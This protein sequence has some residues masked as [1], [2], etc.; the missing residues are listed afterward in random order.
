MNEDRPSEQ[1][2]LET[3]SFVEKVED[4][5]APNIWV[6]VASY[7]DCIR[8]ATL[9]DDDGYYVTLNSDKLDMLIAVLQR[10][11]AKLT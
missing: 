9:D 8:I 2:R 1:P 10:S 3:R 5:N 11:K 4:I 7:K 6:E